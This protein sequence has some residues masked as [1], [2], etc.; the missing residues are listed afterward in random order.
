MWG[1]MGWEGV[2][3]SCKIDGR[4]DADL[5]V[6]ILE[7]ELQASL[8]HWGK[9]S[10][11]V[12]FQQD[13]DPKH[14]SK[15]AKIW[16]EDHD[17]VVMV[18]PAQSPD[19]NPIE[20]LWVYI[21]RRLAEYEEPPKRINELQERVEKEWEAIPASVCHDLISSMSRRVVEVLKAKGGYTR[22]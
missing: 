1:C 3:Y 12:V 15:K 4:M 7:D 13:N 11:E 21:K 18:W 9:T 14:T 20:H 19:L 10:D 8:D 17:F 6:S 22:Y 5:Y 16:F 2:G